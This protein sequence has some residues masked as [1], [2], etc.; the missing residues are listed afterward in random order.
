[1]LFVF[2]VV[3]RSTSTLIGCLRGS[4]GAAYCIATAAVGSV[5]FDFIYIA[6]PSA[7]DFQVNPHFVRENCNL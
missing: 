6:Y 3:G 7:P 2:V 1:M 5:D 4:G